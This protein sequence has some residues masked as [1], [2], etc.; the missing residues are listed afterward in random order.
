MFCSHLNFS[1][2][3]DF[4]MVT[5][6]V[7]RKGFLSC[8]GLINIRSWSKTNLSAESFN[9]TFGPN[10][11]APIDFHAAKRTVENYLHCLVNFTQYHTAVNTR[12]K[13]RQRRKRQIHFFLSPN[14][15][16]CLWLK[17][18]R[19]DFQTVVL[20]SNTWRFCLMHCKCYFM[21]GSLKPKKSVGDRN[22]KMQFMS[23]IEIF[24]SAIEIFASE[25]F[26]NCNACSDQKYTLLR[27]T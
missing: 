13:F 19:T 11:F 6:A 26:S 9:K 21:G 25:Y 10:V 3:I 27:S 8:T 18:F 16:I 5:L 2:Q 23:P 1:V 20:I 12:Q 14:E 7:I 17:L 24:L 22:I 4:H 15:L